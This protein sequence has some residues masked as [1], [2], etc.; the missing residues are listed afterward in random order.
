MIAALI[1]LNKPHF[2]ILG[3]KVRW[4]EVCSGRFPPAAAKCNPQA[5]IRAEAVWQSNNA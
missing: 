2:C 3:L 1:A 4:S 5:G